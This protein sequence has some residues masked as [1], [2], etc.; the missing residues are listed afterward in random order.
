MEKKLMRQFV[1]NLVYIEFGKNKFALINMMLFV[2]ITDY[3]DTI[4]K[5]ININSRAVR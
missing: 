1:T 4:R 2:I 5:F 3:I